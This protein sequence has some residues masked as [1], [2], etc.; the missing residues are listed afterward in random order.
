MIHADRTTRP[1]RV[2]VVEDQRHLAR[3]LQYV[4]EGAGYEVSNSYDGEQALSEIDRFRPDALVLGLVLPGISGLEVLRR[5]RADRR[6]KK[7][8]ILVMTPGLDRT[9]QHG[10]REA[11]ADAICGKP[12]V[13]SNLLA[14]L[15]QL[16]VPPRIPR[17]ERIKMLTVK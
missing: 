10:L 9:F 5:L 17:P 11:G 13:P 12:L 7:L 3:F 1:G 15:W 4:L 8:A 16:A 6:T 14:G 2:L